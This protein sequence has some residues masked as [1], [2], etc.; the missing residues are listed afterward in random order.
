MLELWQ[1][2]KGADKGEKCFKC[3]PHAARRG[4]AR[5][6]RGRRT[7]SCES[8]RSSGA[9]AD[10]CAHHRHRGR[11]LWYVHHLPPKHAE[12]K[13]PRTQ[14]ERKQVYE[15]CDPHANQEDNPLASARAVQRVL[16]RWPHA[17]NAEPTEAEVQAAHAWFNSGWDNVRK[18]VVPLD[19]CI[20]HK[21]SGACGDAAAC[22]CIRGQRSRAA[23]AAQTCLRRFATSRCAS[24]R[25]R[26]A[27]AP[28]A[29][30]AMSAR[31]RPLR[32]RRARTRR[33]RP[34]RMTHRRQ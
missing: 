3:A 12:A 5:P 27:P 14:L 6:C 13:R 25:A 19:E 28:P 34:R 20:G 23:A 24:R 4:G 31:L 21:R 18:R 8:G 29:P 11:W 7:A 16:C 9:S 32:R 2:G 10:A 22:C 1:D 17:R 26:R 15:Q 33:R 30:H